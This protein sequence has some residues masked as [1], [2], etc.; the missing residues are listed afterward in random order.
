MNDRHGHRGG[1][2]VLKVFVTLVQKTLRP[3][4][5][6]GRIGGE[7]FALILPD[8]SL[9]GATM[10]AERLRQLTESEVVAFAGTHIRFTA[11]LGVA[12]YGSDG[13]TYESVIEA[14]DSRMYRAKQAG[15]NQVIAR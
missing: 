4:D 11:S 1:D 10:V 15:R 6:A 8:T 9:E 7:E 12:Q 3:S 2:E 5:L 13:D 14:A